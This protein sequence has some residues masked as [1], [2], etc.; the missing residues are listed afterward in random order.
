MA[1]DKPADITENRPKERND[2]PG[3]TGW[4]PYIFSIFADRIKTHPEERRS[5]PRTRTA[6][7]RR[8]MLLAQSRRQK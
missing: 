7:R 6:S 1:Y 5:K 4:D 8:A 3:S 2:S